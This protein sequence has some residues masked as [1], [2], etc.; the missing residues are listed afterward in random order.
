MYEYCIVRRRPYTF[1]QYTVVRVR[2]V[3]YIYARLRGWLCV[4]RSLEKVLQGSFAVLLGYRTTTNNNSNYSS[5]ELVYMYRQEDGQTDIQTEGQTKS[6][7]ENV[8]K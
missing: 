8:R 2:I 5:I 6:K 1:M 3:L 7:L 4:W